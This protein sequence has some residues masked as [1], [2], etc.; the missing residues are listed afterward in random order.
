MNI[1]QGN[2]VIPGLNVVDCSNISEVINC[3]E[4]G[5]LRRHTSTL[6]N[7][8]PSAMHAIFSLVLEHQWTDPGITYVLFLISSLRIIFI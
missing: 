6:H 2:V 7:G 8:D 4:A 5:L 1:L 3:L